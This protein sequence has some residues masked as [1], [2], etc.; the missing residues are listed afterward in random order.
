MKLFLK[1][2]SS[3]FIY[4]D[5]N[6]ESI[7]AFFKEKKVH[8]SQFSSIFFQNSEILNVITFFNFYLKIILLRKKQ[9]DKLLFFMKK[10]LL[11]IL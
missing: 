8:F 9:F 2:L 7:L 5:I 3:Y 4:S 1:T 11:S 10:T 6:R